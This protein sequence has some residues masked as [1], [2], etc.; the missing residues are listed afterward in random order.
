MSWIKNIPDDSAKTLTSVS[1]ETQQRI[2]WRWLAES[3]LGIAQRYSGKH[4]AL[5]DTVRELCARMARGSVPSYEEW[6]MAETTA[7][8][9]RTL[10]AQ[11]SS[12]L[13]LDAA[14]LAAQVHE[15]NDTV[16]GA[17]YGAA[18]AWGVGGRAYQKMHSAL[19]SIIKEELAK[20]HLVKRIKHVRKATL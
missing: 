15:D 13:A 2:L 11:S 7:N 14:I 12:G 19:R 4:F 16:T 10:P 8:A 9:A 5:V 18:Q 1:P 6:V 20:V 17:V 3:I